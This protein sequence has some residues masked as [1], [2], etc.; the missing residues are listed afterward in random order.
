ML[1][2][3]STSFELRP[4]RCLICSGRIR[5]LRD[6]SLDV[7]KLVANDCEARELRMTNWEKLATDAVSDSTTK[8]G[9][10]LE[11]GLSLLNATLDIHHL[12]A[13]AFLNHQIQMGPDTQPTLFGL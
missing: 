9:A 10:L 13:D 7:L 8:T 6:R 4:L 11:H 2:D 5:L 3:E 1:I 12:I